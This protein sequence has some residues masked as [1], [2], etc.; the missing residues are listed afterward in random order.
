MTGFSD[1]CPEVAFFMLTGNLQN[2]VVAKPTMQ[3]AQQTNSCHI[4]SYHARPCVLA[5]SSPQYA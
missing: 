2:V 3:F 1:T 5:V 4:N